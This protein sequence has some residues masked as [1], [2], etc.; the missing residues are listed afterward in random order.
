MKFPPVQNWWKFPLIIAT[1]FLIIV[2]TSSIFF[3]TNDLKKPIAKVKSIIK[4]PIVRENT[5]KEV[6]G[7]NCSANKVGI[8]K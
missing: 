7:G 4:I 1:V 3:A 5:T 2:V 8:K 6:T